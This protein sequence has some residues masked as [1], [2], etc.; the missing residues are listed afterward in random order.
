MPKRIIA[1]A[2]GFL[3]WSVLWIGSEPVIAAVAPGIA[4][5]DGLSN[6]TDGYLALKVILSVIFS[7]VSGYLSS[8]FAGESRS[9]P[10]ILGVVLL[11]VGI[12]VQASV[13][14]PL[15]LWYHLT[16]LILLLPMTLLG[17]R[18]RHPGT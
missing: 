13:W 5:G 15:P 2:V 4:P 12:G 8:T 6:I 3:S 1:V 7:F 16:F 14:T 18:L 17:G 10:L 11:L 9:A